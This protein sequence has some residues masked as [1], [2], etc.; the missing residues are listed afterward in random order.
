MN[1]YTLKVTNRPLD[2]GWRAQLAV[3]FEPIADASEESFWVRVDAVNRSN[4]N[5]RYVGIVE[6]YLT[7]SSAHGLKR[8]FM[9]EFGQEN[10]KDATAQ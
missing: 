5:T 3:E 6:D 1:K 8:G 7:Y 10:V 9:V 4:G 2:A